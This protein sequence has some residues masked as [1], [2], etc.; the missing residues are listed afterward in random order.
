MRGRRWICCDLRIYEYVFSFLLF[1]YRKGE[2]RWAGTMVML[3]VHFFQF[4]YVNQYMIF[5]LFL[6]PH[7]NHA[8]CILQVIVKY[9]MKKRRKRLFGKEGVYNI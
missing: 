4:H 8:L 9:M 3:Q 7:S 1:G 5:T 2:E 6:V